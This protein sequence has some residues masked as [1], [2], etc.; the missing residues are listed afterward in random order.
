M[1]SINQK[2]KSK[3]PLFGWIFATLS[4]AVEYICPQQ[5]K[6]FC[7]SVL[8]FHLTT[9]VLLWEGKID[10]LYHIEFFFVEQERAKQLYMHF[11]KRSELYHLYWQYE[12]FMLQRSWKISNI[13]T[14]MCLCSTCTVYTFHY[15]TFSSH[16]HKTH[17][18]FS[19]HHM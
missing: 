3:P 5:Q 19:D 17:Y 15:M 12:R 18:G 13:V 4:E 8:Y 11:T 7:S 9:F 1:C 14:L 16:P 2:D 6:L 10:N